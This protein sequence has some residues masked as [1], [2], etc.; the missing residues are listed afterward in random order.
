[1][2]KRQKF[3]TVIL[4]LT[5][6][7]VSGG[8]LAYNIH[9]MESGELAVSLHDLVRYNDSEKSAISS[10]TEANLLQHDSI[11]TGA[12]PSETPEDTAVSNKLLPP[13]VTPPA[14]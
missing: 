3:D 6:F 10:F 12:A 7:A 14:E 11:F 1:M 5:L 2:K 9:T 8:I 13:I 4:A